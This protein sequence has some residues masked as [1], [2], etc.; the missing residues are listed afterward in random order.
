M[1]VSQAIPHAVVSEYF[2]TYCSACKYR[3]CTST[4][5]GA[6][7]RQVFPDLRVGWVGEAYCFFGLE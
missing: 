2:T 3:V 1:G 4:H 6:L 7:I 5:I